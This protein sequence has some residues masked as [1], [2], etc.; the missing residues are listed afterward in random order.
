MLNEMTGADED[1]KPM[2]LRVLASQLSGKAPRDNKT[3]AAAV[4]FLPQLRTIIESSNDQA[5]THA[6]IQCIDRITE[7]YGR[8]N[9]DQIVEIAAF[10]AEEET[11]TRM[12]E[13]LSIATLLCLASLLDV[14]KEGAVPIV[15]VTLERALAALTGSDIQN[16]HPE[17][18]H[19]ACAVISALLS[20]VSYMVEE[21]AVQRVLAAVIG[22]K[23]VLKH[24]SAREAR[25]DTLDLVARRVDVEISIAC[26]KILWQDAVHDDPRVE[27]YLSVFSTAVNH[28]PKAS[29]MRSAD[30]VSS[31]ILEV[32]DTQPTPFIAS[33]TNATTLSFVYKLNDT[34][35]RPIF[36]SWMDWAATPARQ[37]SLFSLLT[38][39]FS[40]LKSIVTSYA[41]YTLLL[42]N[43]VLELF[44]TTSPPVIGTDSQTLYTNVMTALIAM[45]EHDADAFFANPS[46]FQPLAT[47]LLAQLPLFS[48]NMLRKQGFSHTIPTVVALASAVQDTPSHLLF[49]NHAL[50]QLRHH[51]SSHVRLAS[52]STHVALTESEEVG[53]EWIA[54]VVQGAHNGEAAT[55]AGSR[56]NG[57]S[58][59]T[60]IYVSEM[61]EDDDEEV[62]RL[63]R[64]WVRNVR[65]RVGEEVFET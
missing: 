43:S 48:Y 4:A 41:S 20:H 31:F 8:K 18:Y 27:S 55:E 3:A 21:D 10:L 28:H 52:I 6:A 16:T 25:K 46:H 47:N 14:I 35:F 45:L 39:F 12:S 65:E 1:L 57:G 2:A 56:G 32:L 24:T 13:Q 7:A 30:F 63:V 53:D 50:C 36:S 61:L 11:T 22:N 62:E 60:M 58:G 17:V 54:T 37:L 42:A 23:V 44:T 5:L 38:H 15:I 34:T 40:T 51:E 9:V 64:K 29:I 19:A 59:E 33:S 49:I 26:L